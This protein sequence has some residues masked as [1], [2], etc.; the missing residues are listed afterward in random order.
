[1]TSN[2]KN[3]STLANG[4]HNAETPIGDFQYKLDSP[5]RAIL[6]FAYQFGKKGM[7]SFDYEYVDY[8]KMKYRNGGD[9]YGF[10]LENTDI[11]T[12]YQSVRNLRFGGEIKPTEALSLRAGYELFGNPYKSFINNTVQPNKD[13]SFNTINAGF[14]YRINLSLIHI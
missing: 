11:K 13:F 12:I 14:G 7:I 6:S 3:V 5:T 9:G 2:L 1:M 8:S 10:S 4:P